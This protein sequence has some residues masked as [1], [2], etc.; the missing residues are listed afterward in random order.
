MTRQMIN[1]SVNQTLSRTIL[2]FLTTFVVTVVL[3]FFGGH[4]IHGFAYAMVVGLVAGTYSTVFIASP[5]LLWLVKPSE[6]PSQGTS[7]PA[8]L[9]APER[10]TQP[11]RASIEP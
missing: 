3:Y 9:A 2:T 5:V 10:G 4:S 1:D 6:G 11:A 7:L 8:K